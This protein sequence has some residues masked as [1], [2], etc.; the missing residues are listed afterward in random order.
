MKKITPITAG[1]LVIATLPAMASAEML[2]WG[3]IEVEL[4]QSHIGSVE[5]NSTNIADRDPQHTDLSGKFGMDWGAIGAQVDLAY[6][7]TNVA[8]DTQTGFLNGGIAA[9]HVNYDVLPT[10]TLGGL[11]GTG[12]ATPAADEG[13]DIGF[14]AAEAAFTAGNFNLVGQLGEFDSEDA[15]GTDAFH[16]GRFARLSGLYALGNAAVIEAEIGF[17]DGKQDSPPPYDMSGSTWG[18][19]YSRQ[20]GANPMAYSVGLDGGRFT[21][22]EETDNGAF[23]ETRVTLGLT[24]WFGGNSVADSKRKGI[25]GQPDFSRI[26]TAGNN[27]D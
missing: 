20:I 1:A 15:T 21:N 9:V 19:K 5:G 26:V 22:G 17:Y 23:D 13:V 18:V 7:S 6:S 14:F 8:K 3:Q 16:D 25:F 10:L 2:T 24:A 12:S 4:G 11:I 27:V